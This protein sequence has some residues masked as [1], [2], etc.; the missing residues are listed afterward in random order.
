[1]ARS[2]Q[3]MLTNAMQAWAV[4]L[5]LGPPEGFWVAGQYVALCGLSK[6]ALPEDPTRRF[7]LR[8]CIMD[9]GEIKPSFTEWEMYCRETSGM[10]SWDAECYDMTTCAYGCDAYYGDRSK[11]ANLEGEERRELVRA[12]RDMLYSEGITQSKRCSIMKCHAF[13]AKKY[14]GTCRELQFR[15]SC[16]LSQPSQYNCDV[17]CNGAQRQSLL[18][19]A[20]AIVSIFFSIGRPAAV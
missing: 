17:D 8:R 16:E 11:I 2:M 3:R 5:V 7:C 10:E 6:R 20:A 4:L 1:M 13:C 9:E 14:L 15:H 12:T 18:L 19:A